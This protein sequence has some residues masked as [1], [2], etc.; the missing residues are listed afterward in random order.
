MAIF[1]EDVYNALMSS[2]DSMASSGT[3]RKLSLSHAKNVSS[4]AEITCRKPRLPTVKRVIGGLLSSVCLRL[5]DTVRLNCESLAAI[6]TSQYFRGSSFVSS[7]GRSMYIPSTSAPYGSPGALMV[8][9]PGCNSW[10]GPHTRNSLGNDMVFIDS[11]T[12][13]VDALNQLRE[14][15]PELYLI[16]I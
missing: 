11:R 16:I 12:L 6:D 1:S 5:T 7:G 8:T 14:P 10:N 4:G 15:H 3:T 13:F 9:S 2:G